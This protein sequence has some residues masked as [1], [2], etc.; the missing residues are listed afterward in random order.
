MKIMVEESVDQ[1]KKQRIIEHL[2]FGI[3]DLQK[4]GSNPLIINSIAMLHD[5]LVIE[6][7]EMYAVKAVEVEDEKAH[8]TIAPKKDKDV[9]KKD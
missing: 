3:T 2:E 4:F 6:Y 5:S 8:P 1:L 7:N 9:F